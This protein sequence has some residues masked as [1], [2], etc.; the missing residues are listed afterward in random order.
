MPLEP[1]DAY[2]DGPEPGDVPDGTGV[3]DIGV[4][5]LDGRWSVAGKGSVWLLRDGRVESAFASGA[6]L[7]AGVL[8]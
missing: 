6:D 5:R 8:A 3:G 2:G 1:A 4:Y 7:P